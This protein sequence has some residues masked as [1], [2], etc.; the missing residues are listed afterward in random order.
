MTS[1]TG[2]EGSA[3]NMLRKA[4]EV[5]GSMRRCLVSHSAQRGPIFN[6]CL[7]AGM[8]PGSIL[9]FNLWL[10]PGFSGG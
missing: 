8:D 7:S 6:A 5:V 3:A 2:D 1:G 9:H 4:A 10:V